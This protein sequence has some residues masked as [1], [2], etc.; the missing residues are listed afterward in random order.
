MEDPVWL[1][2]V[3][4]RLRGQCIIDME[5]ALEEVGQTLTPENEQLLEAR[6]F[7]CDECGWWCDVEELNNETDRN[8]C[9]DCSEDDDDD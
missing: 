4:E 2:A 6:V 8:M 1:E 5:Q 3:V 9:D 7:L